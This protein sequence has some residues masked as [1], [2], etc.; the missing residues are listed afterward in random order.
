[1]WFR[2]NTVCAKGRFT[3]CLLVENGVAL[4]AQKEAER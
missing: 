4:V 1:M 3:S 2:S